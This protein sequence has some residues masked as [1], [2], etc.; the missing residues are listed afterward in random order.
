MRQLGN[1][2]DR[3]MDPGRSLGVNNRDQLRILCRLQ[4]RRDFRRL[5]DRSPIRF[6]FVDFRAEP[7]RD[8]RHP[9][10]ERAVDA[11]HDLVAVLDQVRH[12]SFHPR[13]A[14]ARDWKRDFVLRAKHDAQQ[15]LN[16]LHHLEKIGIEMPDHRRRI[17]SSRA[18]LRSTGPDRAE[19]ARQA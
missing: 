5:D 14:G 19:S 1:F 11:D 2:L 18:D 7:R 6:D 9:R 8:F 4:R 10:S 13:G 17:A 12:H 3:L 16:I 15:L